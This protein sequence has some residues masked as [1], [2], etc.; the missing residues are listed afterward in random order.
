MRHGIELSQRAEWRKKHMFRLF[1]EE[2]LVELQDISLTTFCI[3]VDCYDRAI[4]AFSHSKKYIWA[5]TL[6]ALLLVAVFF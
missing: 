1:F 3:V 4:C 5:I 2:R 6:T